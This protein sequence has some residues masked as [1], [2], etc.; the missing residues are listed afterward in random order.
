MERYVK[1]VSST[2]IED[3]P[4]ALRGQPGGVL[5]ALGYKPL[6]SAA[7]DVDWNT[8]TT[9]EVTYVDQ[10]D[11]ILMEVAV[12]DLTPPQV[13]ARER[14]F[15]DAVKPAACDE[16]RDDVERTLAAGFEYDGN[17]YQVHREARADMLAVLAEL[18]AGQTNPHGGAWRTADNR[19]VAMT[20]A[21]CL[22]FL[23]AA[24]SHIRS[25]KMA[26]WA[27]KDA[28]MSAATRQ[29]VATALAD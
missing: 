20:D 14:S 10:G 13:D 1:L 23:R 9:G 3:L 11:S 18:V 4:L 25:V 8:Q 5:M 22:H 16:V 19:M 26:S 6:R 7:L 2:K 28:I 12:V 15:A 29:D 27:K 24:Q 17:V 21:E